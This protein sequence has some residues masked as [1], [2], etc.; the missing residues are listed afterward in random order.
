MCLLSDFKGKLDKESFMQIFL[1]SSL[2]HRDIDLYISPEM[3]QP[4]D[5]IEIAELFEF[6]DE[7]RTG[8]I[9]SKDLM[10]LFELA[11]RLK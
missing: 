2:L 9:E 3:N 8:M 10:N 6:L 1:N 7:D 5:L 4:P 11:E